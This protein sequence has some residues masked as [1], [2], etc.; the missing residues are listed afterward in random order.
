MG[1]TVPISDCYLILCHNRPW[2]VNAL[3][4]YLAAQ[5]HDVYIHVDA[6]ASIASEI[7]TGNQITMVEDRLAVKWGS[8]SMI[9][10]E[11]SCMREVI[12]SR[13]KYRYVHLLSGQCLPAVGARRTEEIL[14]EAYAARK[15]FICCSEEPITKGWGRDGLLYRIA[16][17]YPQFMVDRNSKYHRLFHKWKKL[18]RY[19]GLRR[20][21]WRKFAPFHC[22]SQWWSLTYD[23][24]CDMVRYVDE[25]PDFYDFFRH[26]FCSDEMFVQTTIKRTTHAADITGS[27]KRFMIWRRSMSPSDLVPEEWPQVWESGNLFARKFAMEPG[28]TE[29]YLAELNSGEAC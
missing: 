10:A 1:S 22:G 2:Q 11:M 3:S 28:E 29:R 17:W 9:A 27:N 19:T 18:W 5:G 25:N 8:F 23:C 14:S 21:S 12:A 26:T 4:E 16:V 13:K 7:R 24:V 15:Q 6:A 20:F